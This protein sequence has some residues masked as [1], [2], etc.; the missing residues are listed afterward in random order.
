MAKSI[1]QIYRNGKFDC[2]DRR[3]YRL[4]SRYAY[5]GTISSDIDFDT[6]GDG[7]CR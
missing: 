5:G 4:P 7:E 2:C 1:Q 6:C 3:V